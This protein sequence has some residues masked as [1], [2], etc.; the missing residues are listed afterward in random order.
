MEK[1]ADELQPG[2][3]CEPLEIVVTPELNQQFLFAQEDFD[4]RYIVRK[5]SKPPVVHPAL[6]L[7]MS[8]NTK[9]PSF[10]LSPGTGSILATASVDFLNPAHVDKRLRVTW[11]I[12]DSYEKR[13]RSYIVMEASM[14]DE[15]GVR[16]LRRELHITFF[17][18]QSRAGRDGEAQP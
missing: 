11:E 13:G 16:I 6:L 8:A 18:E 2:D 7:Q 12:T 17:R 9:S 1:F 5:G 4:P 14:T 3:H 15:D 10:R